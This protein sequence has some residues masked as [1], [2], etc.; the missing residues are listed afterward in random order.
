MHFLKLDEIE[1]QVA[2]WHQEAHVKVEIAHARD[3]DLLYRTAK[4]RACLQGKHLEQ[5]GVATSAINIAGSSSTRLEP[6]TFDG[7][8]AFFDD[9]KDNLVTQKEVDEGLIKLGLIPVTAAELSRRDALINHLFHSDSNSTSPAA[10][11]ETLPY[12]TFNDRLATSQSI[13]GEDH[14]LF[15][16]SP[17]EKWQG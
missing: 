15:A 2:N 10:L 6:C 7:A 5:P 4:S 12:N 14:H 3:A 16:P 8:A 11:L 9:K 1:D 13:L 17:M